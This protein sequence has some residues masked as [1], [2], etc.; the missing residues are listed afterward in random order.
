MSRSES[1][2]GPDWYTGRRQCGWR[3]QRCQVSIL[4]A[5][6]CCWQA[7]YHLSANVTRISNLQAAGT[8]SDLKAL[9]DLKC[10]AWC[11]ARGACASQWA[12]CWSQ[13]CT[14]TRHQVQ[15]W[16]SAWRLPHSRGSARPHSVGPTARNTLKIP[17][18]LQ[19]KAKHSPR[20]APHLAHRVGCCILE[21]LQCAEPPCSS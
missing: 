17:M 6:M 19:I 16:S 5:G 18:Q 4:G 11:C 9:L 1:P 13:P 15:Q 20:S 12:A 2:L 21:L 10:I 14:V 8:G 7:C 3:T